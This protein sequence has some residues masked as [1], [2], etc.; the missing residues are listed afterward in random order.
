MKTKGYCMAIVLSKKDR[1]ELLLFRKKLVKTLTEKKL[2][3][4]VDKESLRHQRCISH[5]DRTLI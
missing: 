5:R 2:Y 3:N 1:D 4:W